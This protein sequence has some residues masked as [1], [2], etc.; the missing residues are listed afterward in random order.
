MD[1]LGISKDISTA[2]QGALQLEDHAVPVVN[3][4]VTD[5]IT[6]AMQ[7]EQPILDRI[8]SIIKVAEQFQSDFASLIPQLNAALATVAS[9]KAGL[10]VL[11]N[12][13]TTVD[14]KG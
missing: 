4:I 5:T 2:L 7:M 3:Q 6:K 13:S 1:I 12:V 14:V 11:P 8:D 9:F 10:T